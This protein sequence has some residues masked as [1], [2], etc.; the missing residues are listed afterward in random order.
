MR[1]TTAFCAFCDAP[2]T[3][4][5]RTKNVAPQIYDDPMCRSLANNLRFA[6]RAS[7]SAKTAKRRNY[8]KIQHR[9]FLKRRTL[10]QRANRHAA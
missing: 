3:P 9:Y 6:Q 5:P 4:R 10:L 7:R 1:H 2:F 8:Y